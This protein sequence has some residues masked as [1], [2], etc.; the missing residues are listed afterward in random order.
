MITT[1]V[2]ALLLLVSPATLSSHS[3]TT[4][5]PPGPRCGVGTVQPVCL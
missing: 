4:T 1:L 3:G 5:A 2:I